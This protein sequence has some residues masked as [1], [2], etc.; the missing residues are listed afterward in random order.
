MKQLIFLSLILISFGC[1]LQ[2]QGYAFGSVVED[3][4]LKNTDGKWVS[5]SD[6]PDA[7]AY[8]I[9]FTCNHCPYAKLYEDR[10]I[11]MAEQYRKKGIVLIAINP[12]DAEIV[13]E[14]SYALMV[15]RAKEKNYSFPYLVDEKQEV[16]PKFGASRTPQVYLLDQQ[17]KLRYSGAIDDAPK[18]ASLVQTKYLD[19]AI[20]ALENG[21]D[22]DP[23]LTKAVGCSIKKKA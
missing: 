2:A 17:K 10:I 7:K 11:A 9:V 12:N 19:N 22:P 5:L 21:K 4:K 3:F 1:T 15:A 16:Y 18:D 13:P 6:F 8:V 14:D 23:Q 20:K